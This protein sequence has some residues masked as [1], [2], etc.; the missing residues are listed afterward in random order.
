M[1]KPS[2]IECSTTYDLTA[3]A[4]ELR[5]EAAYGQMG[6]AARTLVREDDLRIVVIAMR[7]G[8]VIPEHQTSDTLA[9]QVVTGNVRLTLA[10]GG[11]RELTGA[12]LLVLKG[13]V[14]HAVEALEESALL[15][16]LGFRQTTT[17]A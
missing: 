1:S 5:A 10:D 7:A 15:L 16:T 14:R 13:G 2:P 3:V 11:S 12:Q 4:T 8:A 6:H 9:L 17:S